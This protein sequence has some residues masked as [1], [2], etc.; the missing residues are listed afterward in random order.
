MKDR[1]RFTVTRQIV[2]PESAEDG[3]CDETESWCESGL[4]LRSAIAEVQ[5]TRTPHVDGVQ[6]IEGDHCAVTIYNGME[7]LT[8]AQECR[9]LH[10]PPNVSRA[11]GKRIAR[12]VGARV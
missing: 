11:S 5:Q 4:S 1:I 7:F 2:T 3:C 6:S 8:G 9:T 10:I 12:L